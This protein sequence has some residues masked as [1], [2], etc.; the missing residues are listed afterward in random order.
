MLQVQEPLQLPKLPKLLSCA[1]VRVDRVK[2]RLGLEARG[3]TTTMGICGKF[4]ILETFVAHVCGTQRTRR[5]C[6]SVH[7]IHR[8]R[9]HAT[10]GMSVQSGQPRVPFHRAAPSRLRMP[11]RS[12]PDR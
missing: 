12:Q 11:Q 4:K 5:R 3:T 6:D 8:P 10:H 9:R 2:T 1:K 7:G